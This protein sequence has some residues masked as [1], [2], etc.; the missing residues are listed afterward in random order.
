VVVTPQIKKIY[1]IPFRRYL[2][3]IK[4]ICKLGD[5]AYI[6]LI[7]GRRA[8]FF[9]LDYAQMDEESE[10]AIENYITLRIIDLFP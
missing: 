3:K 6:S 5:N 1:D 10:Y 7:L 4:N 9:F 2:E 8:T